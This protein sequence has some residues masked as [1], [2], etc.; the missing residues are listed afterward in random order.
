MKKILA[1]ILAASMTVS[2][3]ACKKDEE[4]SAKKL[5]KEEKQTVT[6]KK[7][8]SAETPEELEKIADYSPEE[9]L[10]YLVLEKK[11]AATEISKFLTE[12]KNS[13]KQSSAKGSIA[14]KTG[15]NFTKFL[16]EIDPDIAEMYSK[17]YSWLTNA[18]VDM[19]I[20]MENRTLLSLIATLKINDAEIATADTVID[21]GGGNAYVTI[22]EVNK[23][24]LYFEMD[25]DFVS[26]YLYTVAMQQAFVDALPSEDVT[27]ELITKYVTI[28][29]DNVSDVAKEE[30]ELT[31]DGIAM[32]VN[33]VSFTV[34]S[35]DAYNG[36]LELYEEFLDDDDIK[37]F[38][39]EL[40][41]YQYEND[42]E[43]PSEYYSSAEDYVERTYEK[44]ENGYNDLKDSKES[45]NDM[46]NV[47]FEIYTDKKNNI[48]GMNITYDSKEILSCLYAEND[49]DFA[50]EYYVKDDEILYGSGTI[51]N[52]KMSGEV[53][54][55]V[56]Y[57]DEVTDFAAITLKDIDL[58]K[59]D[60][61][62]LNGTVSV[63]PGIGFVDYTYAPDMVEDCELI[64]DF[65]QTKKTEASMTVNLKY[66]GETAITLTLTGA[67][68]DAKKIKVPT[69]SLDVFD[70]KDMEKYMSNI[71]IAT[72]IMNLNK[73][74]VSG[75]IIKL[76]QNLY[77]SAF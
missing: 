45:F 15:K 61:G 31:V 74:N 57:Y 1:L 59:L 58:T 25:E 66:D 5:Q 17:Q 62:M 36:K 43:C 19:E 39:T 60:K 23:T 2:F 10:E 51:E 9:Y 71:N 68:K 18:T 30:D 34:S 37:D 6:A 49:G 55:S 46:K 8:D 69:A 77:L 75:D 38:I 50:V 3:A 63:V 56:P 13:M 7:T 48:V 47:D 12:L 73:A 76:I 22:P 33:K 65:K 70:E 72:I 53:Y 27:S 29:L 14:A 35:D 42:E 20:D 52:D 44:F 41:T 24:P 26:G 11:D 32:D 64:L 40:L 67:E 28:L 4:K 21:F 54:I 16:K